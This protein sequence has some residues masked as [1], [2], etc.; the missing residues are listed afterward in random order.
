MVVAALLAPLMAGAEVR[1]PAIFSDH[2]VLQRNMKVPVWGWSDPRASVTV[3]FAGQKVTTAADEQGNWKVMLDKMPACSEPRTL[4][5]S[6]HTQVV[7]HD[8]LVGDVW[9]C[10]GQSNMGL[11]LGECD[12]AD[13]EV[14]K[15]ND[16]LLRLITVQ[17]HTSVKPETDVKLWNNKP[18]RLCT[19]E[20]ASQFSGVAYFFGR[21]LR[22]DRQIPIGLISTLQGGS[23]IQLWIS[24]EAI[25]S[26]VDADPE[27]ASWLDKRARVLE[28]SRASPT[29][30]TVNYTKS[31]SP[32]SSPTGVTAGAK[33]H[34]P[35][36]SC[37]CPSVHCCPRNTSPK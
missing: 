36:F 17:E 29:P 9:L 6:S 19:P 18:W 3:A 20:N 4:S 32:S 26:N 7:F 8:V 34:F 16:P 30:V 33:D 28:N 22:K 10:S 24:P 31:C 2:M 5:V 27:F 12:D 15:A 11:Y 25:K 35:F 37:N 21:E 23:R 13:E 1:L 14:P